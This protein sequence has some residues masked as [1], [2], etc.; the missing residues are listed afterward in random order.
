MPQLLTA[1]LAK[2]LAE[3]ADG[4]RDGKYH[5]FVSQL[6]TDQYS[7]F[8][9]QNVSG[10]TDEEASSAADILLSD[11]GCDYYKFGP[12]KTDNDSSSPLL[13]YSSIELTFTKVNFDTLV[14]SITPETDAIVLSLSAFDK[15]FLPY[16]TRL[17]GAAVAA[18]YRAKASTALSDLSLKKLPAHGNVTAYNLA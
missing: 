3:A 14:I 4:F 6:N 2:R 18:D 15:F 9:M 17:Y 5:Y 13:S 10:D 16:Y 1:P 12:Y 11:L 7:D 8:N